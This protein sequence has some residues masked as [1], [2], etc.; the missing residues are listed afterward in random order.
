MNASTALAL[1]KT[2]QS[3]WLEARARLVERSVILRRHDA[4]ERRLDGLG[5]QS[6]ERLHELRRLTA[7][8][9]DQNALAEQR[10]RIEPAQ[11][12]AERRDAADDQDGGAPVARLL[13]HPLDLL[14]RT[15]RRLLGRQGAVVD[16]RG[17]IVLRPAVREKCAQHVG[18]LIGTGVAHDRAVEPR[19]AGPVHCR[20]P[21][22]L[23]PH[24]PARTS[25]CRRLPG[26]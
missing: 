11:V 23:R 20:A 7:W 8:T 9:C 4:D 26:T 3:N 13:H 19:Q 10:T 24:D 17:R 22:C 1:E 21:S 2:I 6:L 12:L 14:E 5:A 25:T 16:E 15:D 18:Q